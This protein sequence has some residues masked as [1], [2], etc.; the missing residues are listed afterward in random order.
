MMVM[1]IAITPSLNASSLPFAH[2]ALRVGL[3]S[4]SMSDAESKLRPKIC[5]N[6]KRIQVIPKGSI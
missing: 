4:I 6:A 5:L 1:M 2:P 3:L